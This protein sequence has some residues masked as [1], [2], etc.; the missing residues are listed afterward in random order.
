[1][2]TAVDTI[3]TGISQLATP[4]GTGSL[5]GSA[6]SLDVIHDALLAIV[7]GRVAWVGPRTSWRGLAREEI[8]LGGRAVLPALIDPHTHAVWAG[9]RLADFEARATGMSYEDILRRGGGIRTTMHHTAEASVDELVAL[10]APR[11]EA[12]VRNGAA[13]VEIKSGYGFTRAGELAS[14]QAINALR[15]AFPAVV[16]PTLL[17]HVP[18]VDPADRDEYLD[19]VT[20]ELIPAAR[21][22]AAAVDVFI[23]REAFSVDDARRIFAAARHAGLPVKAHVDQ[24]HVL[25][26]VELAV[27][28]GALS[29]DHLEASGLD[30]FAQLAA[31]DTVGVILPGVA[32]HLGGKPADG[33][34]MIDAG[35]IVA[36]GTDLNPGSSPLYSPQLALAL[37]VRLNRLTPTEAVV[38]A[39]ANAAAALALSDTGR[40]APEMRADFLVLADADW[41]AVAYTLGDSAIERMFIAGREVLT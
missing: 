39:T 11:L 3:I 18:P 36:V 40:L 27:E 15:K 41:R 7:A 4:R 30:Q 33:R 13:T 5:R 10:A 20:S 29:V 38:A 25:G 23:E 32:L 1:V 31:S 8:D 16:V 26:G 14:L 9:D 34:A 37:A 2:T 21:P 6:M 12:L 19:M 17:I 24:F 22:L 28:H 35:V